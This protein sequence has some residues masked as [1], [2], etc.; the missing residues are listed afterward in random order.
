MKTFFFFLTRPQ[1]NSATYHDPLFFVIDHKIHWNSVD[2][3]SSGFREESR[4]E[5]GCAGQVAESLTLWIK[6]ERPQLLCVASTHN[7]L[8][9]LSRI[10]GK[11]HR[12]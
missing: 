6:R 3:I 4:E 12:E 9:I 5:D 1:R 2:I 7:S 10:Q 8:E 11:N